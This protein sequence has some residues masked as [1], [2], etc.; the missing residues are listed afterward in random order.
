[1]YFTKHITSQ[2]IAHKYAKWDRKQNCTCKKVVEIS[3][4]QNYMNKKG[5]EAI[6]T[7]NTFINILDGGHG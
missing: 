6:T 4:I 7:M 1:M 5:Y 2:G 3:T